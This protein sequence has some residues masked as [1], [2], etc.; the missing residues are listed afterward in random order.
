MKLKAVAFV[1]NGDIAK[2]KYFYDMPFTL[3]LALAKEMK[4][5]INDPKMSIAIYY[6]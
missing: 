1:T 5:N 6:Y 4:L 2:G 3:A